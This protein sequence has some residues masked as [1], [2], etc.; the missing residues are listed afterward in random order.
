V[1]I[2]IVVYCNTHNGLIGLNSVE[3]VYM[4]LYYCSTIIS[5]EKNVYHVIF[6]IM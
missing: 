4:P 2:F 1:D 5:M 3:G 6:L